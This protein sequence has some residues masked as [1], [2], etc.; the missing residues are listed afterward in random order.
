M[1]PA[2]W[3]SARRRTILVMF[4]N[5]R[6][7]ESLAVAR[8]S[9]GKFFASAWDPDKEPD[10]LKRLAQIIQE[11]KPKKI[12]IN[13]SYTYA[14]ADGMTHTEYERLMSVLP[15]ATKSKVVSA[16]KLAVR[17]LETR[18]A[19]ELEVYEDIA[20]IAKSI[21]AEGFSEKVIQPGKTT[22]DDMVWWF[23]EKVAALK[24]D[25]WFHPTV[26]VQ[27]PDPASKENERSFASR[28]ESEVIMPGDVVHCDFG[29]TYLGL[30]TD[31]QELAYVLKPGE[32]QAP[33]H[34]KKALATG[35]RLQDILTSF[36]AEGKTGNQVLVATLAQ[37][38]KEGIV[39]SIYSH[40][41]GY[42]G[43][44]AGPSIG[45]WDNQIKVPGSG[46]YPL[47]HN[48]LYAIELNAKVKI[49][50]WQDKELRVMLE[51]NAAFTPQ[52]V[53]YMGGRQTEFLLIRNLAGSSTK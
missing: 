11:R 47:Y 44:A 46:D 23:R 31:M 48:T 3:L 29:I 21:I 16:E 7:I 22:T 1:L 50:E 19:P 30:N 6:E 2:T 26:D 38:K 24:L 33:E 12:G 37:A 45:M 8:Y 14:H 53:R 43:H 32:T 39:P 36:F 25:T 13:T 42:H 15:A 17:W 20:S 41:V 4:D 28:P 5:G 18:T 34:L 52:G 40:P 49:K 9:A 27:R 51:Q 10:Q 35:N